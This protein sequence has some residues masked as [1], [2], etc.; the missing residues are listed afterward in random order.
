ME[1]QKIYEMLREKI[2]W[3]DLKPESFLNLSDLA[4]QF[5]VSRTPIKEAL[6][7]LQAEGWVL[8][9][10]SHFMVTPLS[11][12]RIR[13]ISEIRFFLEPRAVMWAMDR[14]TDEEMA[15][16]ER[17]EQAISRLDESSDNRCI[18]ELDAAFHRTLYTATK[19]SHLA[20]MLER[21]LDHYLRFWLCIPRGIDHLRFFDD[22][23]EIVRAIKAKDGSLL[24][25]STSLHLKRS[26][27]EILRAF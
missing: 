11:L 3:L 17:L 6:I 20:A 7:M 2:I 13:E 14:I 9:D 25:Q 18:V 23:H 16:L 26:L 19:N 4:K 12:A 15:D 24:E 10:G 1:P 27:D 8:R 5:Q 22:H 21:L